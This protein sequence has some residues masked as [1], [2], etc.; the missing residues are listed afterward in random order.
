MLECYLYDD[1]SRMKGIT[2]KRN[3]KKRK[4]KEWKLTLFGKYFIIKIPVDINSN[5][6]YYISDIFLIFHNIWLPIFT[7]VVIC[8]LI[9]NYVKYCYSSRICSSTVI[10]KNAII[11]Q[12]FNIVVFYY[13][14]FL[15][16]F[17]MFTEYGIK[18]GSKLCML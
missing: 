3:K 8:N 2:K 16:Y 17:V 7:L 9:L 6:H 18:F 13:S 1:S 10:Y 15:L 11:H 12:K 14:M 4:L 5:L